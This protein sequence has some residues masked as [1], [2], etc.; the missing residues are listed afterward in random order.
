M[1]IGDGNVQQSGSHN[2]SIHIVFQF[3]SCAVGTVLTFENE[4]LYYKNVTVDDY[5][6]AYTR[7][8]ICYYPRFL[9]S[10]VRKE[11]MKNILF[12]ESSKY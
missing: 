10:L 2:F 9:L 1:L 3:Y 7:M 5:G 12:K 4:V 8:N 6:C 11:T